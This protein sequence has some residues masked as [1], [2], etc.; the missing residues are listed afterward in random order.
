MLNSYVDDSA[1]KD[2]RV[3]GVGGWLCTDEDW[4][5][6]ASEW[7]SRIEMEQR[8]SIKHGFPPITRYHAA[9]C[10]S[11]VGEFDRSKGWDN[12]RQLRLIK[13]LIE[14]ITKKRKHPVVG[15]ALTAS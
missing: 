1:S 9:D 4:R 13:R 12:D 14:I 2:R 3:I 15:F 11:L 6:I 10:S 8:N 5:P 7:R